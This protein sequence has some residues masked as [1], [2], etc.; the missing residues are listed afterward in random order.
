MHRED[1]GDPSQAWKTCILRVQSQLYTLTR[2]LQDL[3]TM[4]TEVLRNT[5]KT[6]YDMQ[7]IH[8]MRLPKMH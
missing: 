1:G 4:L 8:S 2:L 5:P 7:V 3:Y 6:C